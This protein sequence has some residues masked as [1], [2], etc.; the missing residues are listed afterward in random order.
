MAI[1]AGLETAALIF[2]L[3]LLFFKFRILEYFQV[4]DR[5]KVFWFLTFVLL[6]TTVQVLDRWQYFFPQ[7]VSF[8][9]LARFAM[10]QLGKKR[11]VRESYIWTVELENGEE[12]DFNPVSS[13]SAI[14]QPSLSTRLELLREEL[15]SEN[16]SKKEHGKKEAQLW[17]NSVRNYYHG[18]YAKK[19]NSVVFY[20]TASPDGISI[21]RT[22][23]YAVE[24]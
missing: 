9:P 7:K 23:L 20:K 1:K 4:L 16:N 6:W 11:E 18:K 15:D 5:I 8:Y 12:K 3:W 10:F 22:E 2:V 13:F 17:A 24:F 14:G 21:L 19:V